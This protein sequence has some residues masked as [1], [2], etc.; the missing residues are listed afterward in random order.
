MKNAKKVLMAV[1]CLM[2][3][4]VGGVALAACGSKGL[5][6]VSFGRFSGKYA[7]KEFS[8]AATTWQKLEDE[9]GL[10]G[11]WKLD[12]NVKYDAKTGSVLGYT[13]T[14]HF[15]AI[16]IQADG[17]KVNE[18][19]LKVNGTEKSSF[20]DGTSSE[21]EVVLIKGITANTED[22]TVEIVWNKDDAT[23]T[24]V[25]YKFVL[26]DTLASHLAPAPEAE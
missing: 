26:V 10:D 13:D 18:P 15:V 22:F 23:K 4:V 9:E 14:Y 12:G 21:N 20:E 19:V 3:L 25:K 24:T 6:T 1:A 7:G 2:L 11:V 17:K 5:D 16:R 8:V